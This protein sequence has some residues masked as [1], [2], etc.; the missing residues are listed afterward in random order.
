MQSVID[1]AIEDLRRRKMLEAT[2]D[3][4]LALRADNKAWQEEAAE[5]D[6]WGETL[7]DGV[8]PE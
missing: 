7:L 8:E 6:L 5:R 2:N 4:F 3:A 1:Q